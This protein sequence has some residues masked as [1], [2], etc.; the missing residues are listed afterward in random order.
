V[1]F[2][3]RSVP[4]LFFD[5]ASQLYRIDVG[6]ALSNLISH[7]S[8]S[9]MKSLVNFAPAGSSDNVLFYHACAE[10]LRARALLGGVV[11]IPLVRG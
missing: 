10:G 11:Y 2:D 9:L 4:Y 5:K 7:L 6:T 8:P 3:I 1:H